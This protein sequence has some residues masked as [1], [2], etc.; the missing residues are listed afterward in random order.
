MVFRTAAAESGFTLVDTGVPATPGERYELT[1]SF[2]QGARAMLGARGLPDG[3]LHVA[4][5]TKS[6]LDELDPF[7]R[8]KR[9][10]FRSAT[11]GDL[12]SMILTGTS[13][14]IN[15]SDECRIL[16]AEP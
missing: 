1:A 3:T 9:V 13:W 11:L 8:N 4:I 6:Y 16:N 7:A 10:T 15:A 14:A 12:G 5:P 2:D